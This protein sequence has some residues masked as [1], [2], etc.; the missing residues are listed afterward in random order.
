MDP[1]DAVPA[2]AA[3]VV[4]SNDASQDNLADPL[5]WRVDE[6]VDDE[7]EDLSDS[8]DE[9]DLS[10]L[11]LRDPAGGASSRRVVE[12]EDEDEPAFAEYADDWDEATGGWSLK[13]RLGLHLPR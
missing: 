13:P 6:A 11:S 12:D 3:P 2:A 9:W 4:P 5:R 10:G 1:A 7:D 8:D